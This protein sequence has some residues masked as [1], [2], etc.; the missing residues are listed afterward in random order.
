MFCFVFLAL[1]I[2]FIYF[3]MLFSSSFFTTE[4]NERIEMKSYLELLLLLLLGFFLWFH[5]VHKFIIQFTKITNAHRFQFKYL[6]YTY[7]DLRMVQYKVWYGSIY[8]LKRKKRK[9]KKNRKWREKIKK[10]LLI[11][12]CMLFKIINK[13]Y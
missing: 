10:C 3:N 4:C 1:T 7:T 11:L 13:Y 2:C 9:K 6:R 5:F 12:T 8:Q